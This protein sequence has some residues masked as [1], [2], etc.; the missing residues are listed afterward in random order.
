MR[1]GKWVTAVHCGSL[2]SVRE[3]DAEK[4]SR[5]NWDERDGRGW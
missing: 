4:G 5:Y 3:E 1:S 2:D